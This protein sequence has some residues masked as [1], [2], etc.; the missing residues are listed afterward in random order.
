MS[1]FQSINY[2]IFHSV[3][4]FSSLVF[5][6]SIGSFFYKKRYLKSDKKLLKIVFFL[7]CFFS[8]NSVFYIEEIN[9]LLLISMIPVPFFISFLTLN[10]FDCYK[11]HLKNLLTSFFTLMIIAIC[12][13]YQIH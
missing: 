12:F 2:Y 7:C 13:L 4:F 11:Y 6:K 3:L 1:Y 10:K 8:L 5:L 9:K